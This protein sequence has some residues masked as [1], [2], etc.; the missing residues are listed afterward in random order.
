MASAKLE[1]GEVKGAV[2]LLYSDDYLVT[3]NQ[4]KLDELD[5]LHRCRLRSASSSLLVVHRT[6]L[7]TVGDRLF[8]YIHP[9]IPA[10]RRLA[11]STINTSPLQVSAAAVRVKTAT[12]SYPNRSAAGP[13]GLRPR[14]L[15]G[16]LLGT[17][18][19]NPL[20]SATNLF[21]IAKTSGGIR[22]CEW[23]CMASLAAKV[24]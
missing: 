6:R 21:T 2:R 23:L 19:D 8:I 13:D 14:H 10:D 9:L 11:P 7:T 24:A 12:M 1:D 22:H 5:R 20:L 15:K 3:E 16:L 17:T 18:D 4:S